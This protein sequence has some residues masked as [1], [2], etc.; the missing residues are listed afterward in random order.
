MP[1]HIFGCLPGGRW[2]PRP[3]R[4]AVGGL[5]QNSTSP[6]GPVLKVSI[7][8]VHNEGHE[9]KASSERSIVFFGNLFLRR[10]LRATPAGLFDTAILDTLLAW[11]DSQSDKRGA[12]VFARLHPRI[13]NPAI[14]TR[15]VSPIVMYLMNSQ[16][17]T[18]NF[19][20]AHIYIYRLLINPSGLTRLGTWRHRVIL[21]YL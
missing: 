20:Q 2:P 17:L 21:I 4:L 9:P 13:P 11:F 3:R 12:G 7:T 8:G 19:H 5:S 6:P 18:P 1:R 16:P 10:W 14:Q 15:S